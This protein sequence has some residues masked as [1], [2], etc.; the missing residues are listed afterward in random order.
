MEDDSKRRDID[1]DHYRAWLDE[2]FE[3]VR[4]AIGGAE[5]QGGSGRHY[6]RAMFTYDMHTDLGDVAFAITNV[7]TKRWRAVATMEWRA[8]APARAA[9]TLLDTYRDMLELGA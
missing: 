5:S 1:L 4:S 7:D 3:H 2:V 8:I 9:E 6:G